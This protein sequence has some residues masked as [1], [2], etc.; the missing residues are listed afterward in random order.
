MNF[1]VISCG[2]LLCFLYLCVKSNAKRN[3]DY[4]FLNFKPTSSDENL[5]NVSS[6]FENGELGK[7]AISGYIDWKYDVDENTMTEMKIYYSQNGRESTYSE[8]PY[9]IPKMSYYDFLDQYWM[10]LIYPFFEDCSNL[11][12]FDKFVPK[13]PKTTYLFDKCRPEPT[14]APETMP[15]GY[16]RVVWNIIGPAT[17]NIIIDVKLTPT[18]FI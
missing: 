18:G 6:R 10:K 17:F 2:I 16:Y 3:W 5:L 13:W 11:P 7:P 14:S 12:S 9:T 1:A 4:E 8:L 15:R